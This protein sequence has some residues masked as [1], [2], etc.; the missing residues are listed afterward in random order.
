MEKEK[1][2]GGIEPETSNSRSFGAHHLTTTVAQQQDLHR[3][4]WI[5]TYIIG[6]VTHF[7]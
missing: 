6:K 4:G 2:T 7:Q 1:P 3:L 5:L